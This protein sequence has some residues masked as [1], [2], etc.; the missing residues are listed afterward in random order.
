M[1]A[2]ALLLLAL[3]LAWAAGYLF[4]G[5]VDHGAPPITA[6]AAMCLLAAAAMVPAVALTP[7]HPLLQPL[8]KR[9]WVPMVMGLTAVAL[10]NL[11]IV[12]AERSVPPS[13][14][15]V[16]GTTVPIVTLLLGALLGSRVG[17]PTPLTPRRLLGIAIA[18]AGLVIFVGWSHLT[19]NLA[20]LNAILVMV[21]GGVVFALNGLFTGS[22]TE[23]LDGAA[24]GA[25][26]MVFATPALALAAFLW[27]EPASL[28][29]TPPVVQALIAEGLL[30]L[31]FAYLVYYLLVAR[32]GAWFASLYAFLVPPLG[33]LLAVLLQGETLTVNHVAGL[34]IVLAG[35][36]LLRSGET[37]AGDSG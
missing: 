15:A 13:L 28:Q 34:T 27:E 6:T 8:R 32:A 7:G 3:S 16:L 9:P 12:A 11:A 35:L 21:S 23:D 37:V 26:T 18:L 20:E 30:G 17:K 31:A 29:W 5:A 1:A 33:V 4:V 22:Q 25:W 36:F 19:S 14:A 24:L 10:P 2:N